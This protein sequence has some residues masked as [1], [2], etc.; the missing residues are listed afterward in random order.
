MEPEQREK[1]PLERNTEYKNLATNT[2]YSFLINYGSHFFTLV[3]SFLLA[4]LIT[5]ESW[6]FLILATSYITIIVI[7][8]SILPPGLN[9]ALNYYIP[10][11]LAL[12]QKYKI[13]SLIRNSLK[14]KLSFLIPVFII[15]VIAFNMFQVLFAINLEDKITLLYI[16][17]PLIIVHSLTRILESINRGFSRFNYNFLYLI[18]KNL[19]HILPLMIFFIFDIN[20]TVEGIAIIV[21]ISF[22]IP[23]IFNC[24]SVSILYLRIKSSETKQNSFKKDIS[25]T[26]KYGSYI[27]ITD[28]INRTWKETQLQGIGIFESAGAVTGYNIAINYQSLS[29]YSVQ[30]ISIPLLTSFTS[31]TTKENFDKVN[32]IYRIAYK[33]TL[34]LLLII[35][36][37]LFF[38]IEFLLDFVFLEDRLIYS[39]ILRLY[40]IAGIF[41]ILGEF[42]QAF[43]NAQ[44]KVKITLG[45]KVFYMLYYIPLFFIGLI[46]FGVEGAIV[47]G[48]LL[49]NFISLVIQI[50]VTYKIGK[51]KLNLQ[52]I[53]TQYLI[54]FISLATTIILKSF[55]YKDLSLRLIEDLGLTLFK[56][57]DFLSIGLFLILFILLNL[58]FNTVSDT[59][60]KNFESLL[61][62]ER[63]LDRA[64][65]KG[66]NG[67]KKFT[68]G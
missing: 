13:K 32:K 47:L 64:L 57:F 11:Y 63:F 27:G 6:D 58:V 2:F 9:Y 34:F 7:I 36:G 46:Y 25:K 42:M 56:N 45:L 17:S 53:I 4:R 59:D 49:G 16:L 19:I 8:T 41:Q 23:F 18:M 54:F 14:A 44:H 60:I 28:L 31:L 65:Q 48:L 5:D 26:F 38:S 55:I 12:N 40:L 21:M 66:L 24:I 15:S 62:K 67:L 39:N 51:I 35:T 50:I 68:R 33:I 22:L 1:L 10:R 61:N 37:A 43:L 52:K 20:I 29:F 30:S 3:Y